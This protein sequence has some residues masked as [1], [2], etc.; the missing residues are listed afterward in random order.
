MAS[1]Q[2]LPLETWAQTLAQARRAQGLDLN[3]LAREL[4]LSLAQIR[5]IEAGSTDAFHAQNYYLRGVQRYAE[6]LQIRLD[7]D[8]REFQATDAASLRN[9]APQRA[10]GIA[11]RQSTPAGAAHL[12]NV[13]ADGSRLGRLVALVVI[14]LLGAGIYLAVGEGWPSKPINDLMT[15][16]ES[17]S[18]SKTPAK[19][20]SGA[21]AAGSLT[22]SVP[23]ADSRSTVA[24][25]VLPST[26]TGNMK[27]AGMTSQTQSQAS[28]NTGTPA[29]PAPTTD[30]RQSDK[31]SAQSLEPAGPVAT[32][33]ISPAGVEGG[34]LRTGA[35]ID[36][37]VLSFKDECWVELRRKDGST[38]QKIYKPGE[39]LQIAT[40]EIGSMVIGN[41]AGVSATRAGKP[42]NLSQFTRG[43]NVA[44]L[45]PQSL[46]QPSP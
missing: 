42:L 17:D 30:M 35:P 2:V 40:D 7:P 13:R 3:T 39:Q 9:T 46:S 37:L 29:A 41:A 23:A 38:E 26:A 16:T 10:K 8:P 14:V 15:R 22:T 19:P 34:A 33:P 4:M 43:G 21:P 36:Q 44:R 31:V 45:N 27:S 32:A 6:R 1:N 18:S 24:T 28:S 25:V 20:S 11:D 12:P 5:G